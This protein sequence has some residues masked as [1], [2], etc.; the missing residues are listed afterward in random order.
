[1]NQQEKMKEQAALKALDYVEGG[2]RL[3]LGTGSTAR[4]FVAALGAKVA[5]GLEVMCVPTS[6]A[7]R[8][9]AAELN[10]PLTE[11]DSLGRLDLTI[12]GADEVDDDLN[13]IKGGG[14]ALLR[15][16]IVAS[17]SD[18][19]VIIADASKYVK[20]LGQFPLPIEVVPFAY[21]TT[22]RKIES[23]LAEH[24][25]SETPNLRKGVSRGSENPFITDGGHYIYD[26]PPMAIKDGQGLGV[27]LADCVGVVEHG[28][29]INLASTIILAHPDKI[30]I[31][32]A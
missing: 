10:I 24:G 17:A 9:Q 19:V 26:C 31:M 18:K 8:I 29:F 30:E 4:Y 23:V 25:I 28:L 22:A 2:M 27:A 15:E 32:G 21:T 6:E 11:L 3:G 20:C 16:K 7:T 5:Q 12:D 1:M 14:G 13:L